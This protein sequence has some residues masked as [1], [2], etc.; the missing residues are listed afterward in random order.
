MTSEAG[1]VDEYVAALP[2]GRREPF[3]RLRAAIIAWQKR[4][5]AFYH[6][7]LYADPARIPYDLIGEL[8]SWIT[9][10]ECASFYVNA[11][12]ARPRRR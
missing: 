3:E 5:L 8:A 4:Y 7:G 12:T 2:P 10:D 9:V 6:F 1:S 11:R